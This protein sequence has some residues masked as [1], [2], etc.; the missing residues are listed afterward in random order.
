MPQPYLQ[1]A[2]P[3]PVEHPTSREFMVAKLASSGLTPEDLGAYPVAPISTNQIPGFLIPYHDQNMYRIRYDRLVDKYIGPKGRIGV[4]WSPH[5]DL[6]TFR[7]APTLYIVEGELKAAALRKRFPGTKVL[8]IG[9]CWMF[10]KKDEVG[11]HRLLPD[12]LR[13]TAPGQRV[14]AVFDDDIETK[15]TIQQAAHTLKNLMDAIG[16]SMTVYRPPIG[17][18]VDDWLMADPMAQLSHMVHV[19]LQ[20]LEISRKNL[21]K[22]LEL[23]LSSEGKLIRNELNTYRLLMDHFAGSTYQDRRLGVI[24]NGNRYD[25]DIMY[26][27]LEYLQD[28]IH[29]A[30]QPGTVRHACNMIFEMNER[31]LV[32]ELVKNLEWD[33]VPRLNSWATKHFETDWPEYTAEWG[34]L[35]MTGL[36]LR[37][38]KPGTKVDH[39]CILVGAQGIGKS[40]FFE[41]LSTFGGFTFY[42]ACTE[43]ATGENRDQAT[44]F[45]Q[46]IVVDLAEGVVFNSKK[47]NSDVI[48]QVISQVEDQYRVVYSKVTSTVPRGF[49]FVGT[50]NRRDQLS[51][52]TGSRRFL[53]L[54]TKKIVRLPYEEKLQILAEVVAHEGE[55]RASEWYKLHVDLSTAPKELIET[56]EHVTD[57][58][59]LVNTQFH[60]SDDTI[61]QIYDMLNAGAVAKAHLS[62]GTYLFLTAAFVAKMINHPS[63]NYVS[64]MLTQ[65][66]ADP[67]SKY[68]GETRQARI[69]QL[70]FPTPQIKDVYLGNYTDPLRMLRGFAFKLKAMQHVQANETIRPDSSAVH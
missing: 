36:A 1:L 21:Y 13:A 16:A 30:F 57:V 68:L 39:C 40:T 25:G 60:K 50:T 8:G 41:E 3:L 61:D 19:P 59:A 17:K 44:A 2:K 31:D 26:A 27:G 22:K 9:G 38:L 56:N 54:E 33:G 45:K 32:Q 48:K 63:T 49:I 34:R 55:I 37:I 18:G 14:V 65:I 46:A 69:P 11:V 24:H 29:Y 43:I 4:W 47:S 67:T 42:H 53:N 64:R 6:D 7:S 52:L 28:K 12:I 5:D 70:Q 10:A 35:L 20:D 58:Q 15:P 51:D 66:V 23:K 62:T